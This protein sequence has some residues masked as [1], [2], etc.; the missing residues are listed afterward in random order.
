[1]YLFW[2]YV[3]FALRVWIFPTT[4]AELVSVISP[5]G[6][7]LHF[8]GIL[9]WI[10]IA[11]WLFFKKIKRIENKKMYSDVF[12]FWITWAMIPLW[13]FLLLGDDFIWRSTSSIRGVQAL[14]TESSINKF[15]GVYPIGLALS[16]G[17]ALLFIAGAIWKKMQNQ[18]GIGL[19]GLA[20]LLIFINI[21]ILYQQYPRY[22]IMPFGDYTID[23]KQYVSIIICFLIVFK[24][25]KR[26]TI[27]H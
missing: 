24:Y 21:I 15:T 26:K 6:Y 13:L 17:S 4:R 1:M 7:N 22:G 2:S 14:H 25:K 16:I 12:F 19:I 20:Y 3:D 5:Y 11:L 8:V 10:A 23:I 9:L 27:K 18:T